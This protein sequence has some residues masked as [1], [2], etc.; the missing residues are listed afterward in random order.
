MDDYGSNTAAGTAVIQ[1]AC[2]GNSN[3][4]WT[5]TRLAS[6]AY[7]L[8]NVHTGLLLTTASTADGALVTQQPDTGSSL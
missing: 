8:T 6:G 2:A 4:Q 1:W 5:A 7:T 3:Q